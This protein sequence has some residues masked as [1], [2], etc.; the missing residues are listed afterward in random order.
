[1]KME[2]VIIIPGEDTLYERFHKRAILFGTG[3]RG[4]KLVDKLYAWSAVCEKIKYRY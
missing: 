1:M 2:S 3:S 4:R